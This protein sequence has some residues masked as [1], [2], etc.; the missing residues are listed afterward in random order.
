MIE[1]LGYN[2]TGSE[3]DPAVAYQFLLNNLINVECK[4]PR[5]QPEGL[6]AVT[7]EKILKNP[8]EYYQKLIKP[9]SEDNDPDIGHFI[10][11]SWPFIFRS[12]CSN[13]EDY[14]C[15]IYSDM[16]HCSPARYLRFVQMYEQLLIDRNNISTF[17][18][19]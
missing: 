6:F 18:Q 12:N 11:R 3:N 1:K 9:L 19:F 8:I 13:E 14:R 2:Y 7:K 4:H 16:T 5:F 15:S 17:N 10:E